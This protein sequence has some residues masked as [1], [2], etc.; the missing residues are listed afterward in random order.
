[1]KNG[2]YIMKKYRLVK[3]IFGIYRIQQRYKIFFW[4]FKEYPDGRVIAR[5]NYEEAKKLLEIVKC[6]DGYDK[7]YNIWSV[8][9]EK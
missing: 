8:C 5:N 6:E 3:N 4:K 9:N 7:E 1:M 2:V